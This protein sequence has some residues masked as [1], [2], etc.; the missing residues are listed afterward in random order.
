MA[1]IKE[2]VLR[3]FKSFR[4]AKI[5]FTNGFVCLVGPNASG[6]TAVTDAIRFVFGEGSLRALRARKAQE[7][8]SVG[9]QKSMIKL[10]IEEDGGEIE[11]I[12]G[13]RSDGKTIY[14]LNG[15]RTTRTEVIDFLRTKGL[16]VGNH[17]VI[18][19]GEVERIIQM[20][21]KERREIID[22]IAGISEFEEKKRESLSELD[23]VQ[24]KVNDALIVLHERE[25]I[26]K[27][28]EE[29]KNAAVRYTE[30]KE[31]QKRVKGTLVLM[32]Y[33]K[34]ENEFNGLSKKFE[35][36]K[37]QQEDGTKQL[38]KHDGRVAEIEM[39]KAEINSRITSR[40]VRTLYEEV[41]KLRGKTGAN[42]SIIEEKEISLKKTKTNLEKLEKEEGELQRKISR[43]TDTKKSSIERAAYLKERI[44]T[45][46]AERKKCATAWEE[47]RKKLGEFDKILDEKRAGLSEI[48]K[49][50]AKVQTQLEI[51]PKT[52]FSKI[53]DFKK[54]VEK[55]ER[56][57]KEL[58][59]KLDFIDE[60]I[61]SVRE[62]I[63]GFPSSVKYIL[64]LKEKI[65]GIHGTVSDLYEIDK[66]FE[67]AAEAAAG[68]RANYIVVNGIPTATEAIKLLK[69]FGGRATFIPLDVKVQ[70]KEKEK[71]KEALGYVIDFVRFD[72]KFSNVFSYVFGDTVVVRD[73]DS[74][75][76]ISEIRAVT[77]DGDLIEP[78]GVVSGGVRKKERTISVGKLEK[79]LDE[80]R[81]ER[82]RCV[83]ELKGVGGELLKFRREVAELEIE[84][85]SA[86]TKLGLPEDLKIRL[87][88]LEEDAKE[89]EREIYDITAE[90]ERIRTAIESSE[91]EKETSKFDEEL[92]SL[93]TERSSI[94]A[95]LGGEEGIFLQE[96]ATQIKREVEVLKDEVRKTDGV[97]KEMKKKNDQ[98]NK[99]LEEKEK[100]L[101]GEGKETEKLMEESKRLQEELDGINVERGKFLRKIERAKEELIK[102]DTL[103]E[104][105]KTRLV[106]LKVEVDSYQIEPI[107]ARKEELETRTAEIESELGRIGPVNLRAPEMYVERLND[108]NE[109]KG[110]AELLQQER[111]A[112][113]KVIEE[114]E[115]RKKEVFMKAF[116]EVNENFKVFAKKIFQN[117]AFLALD[118]EQNPFDGGLKIVMKF[119]EKERN[120]ESLS[121][122]EKVLLTLVFVFSIHMCK[123]SK[124]YILDEAEAALDKENSKRFAAMLKDLSKT[125]QF[126]VVTHN[127]SIVPFANVA[128]GVTKTKN[129]SKI[130]G[131]KLT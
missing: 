126:I 115:L 20:S 105:L 107:D 73:V 26:L 89:I 101:E 123:P 72:K 80:K 53:A 78:S 11:I 44:E 33:K 38:E 3:N 76:K 121:G 57:E 41:E 116:K 16:E 69:Q 118:N 36:Y 52:D 4:N 129:G 34:V 75:K 96:R 94:E 66:E 30:L 10:T 25:G 104:A 2:L 130:V 8:I 97:I 61:A 19:Q 23:K 28:L 15:R 112:V 60:K 24:Q 55:L 39:R 46:S 1:F 62:A 48:Q 93:K 17:N 40:D 21:P 125:T 109:I 100:K 47:R 29:E 111:A 63:S 31:E 117:D 81:K 128:L 54:E 50:I 18:A 22:G 32:E 77:L 64:S 6:K 43:F 83:D 58:L 74:F 59:Q 14:K 7:L 85:K 106:D 70:K 13:I 45:L 91:D 51:A 114:I 42:E 49:E 124:F 120:V 5:Y 56:K 119:G 102:A 98:L 84:K 127:D 35:E 27:E 86:E 90:K 110:K 131:V 88:E 79:E 71:P 113:L 9:S 82:E 108:Y 65:S 103:K 99:Q 37:R 67:I 87:I 122:G 68:A 12:R 95:R 92:L